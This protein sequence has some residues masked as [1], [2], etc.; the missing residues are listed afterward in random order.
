M[1]VNDSDRT[2]VLTKVNNARIN[3]APKCLDATQALFIDLILC[4]KGEANQNVM[5][6]QL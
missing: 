3:N 1:H 2:F 5:L 4:L 6:A